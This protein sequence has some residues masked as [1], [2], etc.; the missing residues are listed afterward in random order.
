MTRRRR[1]ETFGPRQV[2]I[3]VYIME[4]LMIDPETL[5]AQPLVTAL[6]WA[7]IHF[8]WQGTFVALLLAIVMRVL[9]RRSTK[10]RYAAACAALLSML[11]A[12]LATMA[13][14][15]LST[16]DKSASQPLVN[17]PQPVSQPAAVEIEPT[18]VTTQTDIATV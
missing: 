3:Q 18:I 16:P 4:T 17:V 15:S 10:A 14:M 2:Y 5:L 12:P 8:T 9:R 11:A 6:G 13:L 1:R 7:L